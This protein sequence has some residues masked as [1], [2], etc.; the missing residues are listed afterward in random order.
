MPERERMIAAIKAHC[1][2]LSSHDKEAWLDLWAEDAVLEDPVGV[3][4]Y[5]GLEA[6]GGE[7]WKLIKALSPMKLWLSK[8]VIVCGHEAIGMLDGV[9]TQGGKIRR[10]GPIVDHFTFHED[11]KIGMMRAFWNYGDYSRDNLK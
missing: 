10:V 3:D 9:V 8:E 1:R 4:I 2:T 6:L 5:R 11:G 7:F